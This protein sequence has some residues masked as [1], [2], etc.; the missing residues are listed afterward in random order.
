VISKTGL[1][2]QTAVLQASN[3]RQSHRGGDQSAADGPS[4]PI[5]T[6]QIGKAPLLTADIRR[7]V[8]ACP[9]SLLGCR[10]RVLILTGFAGAFRWSELAARQLAIL[11]GPS[12]KRIFPGT[13]QS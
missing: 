6:K 7:I 3:L 9:D 12:E 13:S 5:G 1:P 8:D 4:R 11:Q 10:D 2:L